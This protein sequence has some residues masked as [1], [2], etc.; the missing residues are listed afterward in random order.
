MI[1]KISARS[2]C[3]CQALT[4]CVRDRWGEEQ[5]IIPDTFVSD[6]PRLR[7]AQLGVNCA[8]GG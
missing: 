8:T 6:M 1:T 2:A 4:P 5:Q 7:V 3:G